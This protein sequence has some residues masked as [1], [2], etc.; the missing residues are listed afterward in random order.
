MVIQK[1]SGLSLSAVDWFHPRLV[2]PKSA[3]AEIHDAYN[4][5]E[6]KPCPREETAPGHTGDFWSHLGGAK[7]QLWKLPVQNT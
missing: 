1:Y 5:Q 6:V 7:R 4:N 2:I 3:D